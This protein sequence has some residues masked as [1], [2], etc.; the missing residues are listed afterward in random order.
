MTR[1]N[2]LAQI[3]FKKTKGKPEVFF[4]LLSFFL[5]YTIISS[6][7]VDQSIST[8]INYPIL[9]KLEIEDCGIDFRN[10][11]IDYPNMHLNVYDYYYNG[12]GVAIG[13]IN[14]DGLSDVFLTGNNV[15]N[16][17]YI[18]KGNMQFED[19]SLLSGISDK[20]FWS[21]GV[22]F[23]DINNDGWLD[24]YICHSGYSG[25]YDNK[26]N[27]VYINQ[28]DNTFIE[29]STKF[30][31]KDQS[32]S[33]QSIFFDANKD[34]QIDLFLVNNADFS[35]RFEGVKPFHVKMFK[36]SEY[37]ESPSYN[38]QLENKF[39]INSKNKFDLY[40]PNVNLNDW[41]Q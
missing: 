19:I 21:T 2:L 13:D 33:N 9:Q 12:G 31:L 24:I 7:A 5:C 18:N 15:A 16:R 8:S 41:G 11:I 30:N 35:D 4:H 34:G 10:D 39:F 14:N 6:C 28:K 23:I 26:Q 27:H 40:T 37:L 29:S 25:I 38:N 17:L 32:Y 36:I 1:S 20:D 3:N 22:N